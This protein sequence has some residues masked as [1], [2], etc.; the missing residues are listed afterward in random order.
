MNNYAIRDV[1]LPSPS[2]REDVEDR[3]E[4]MYLATL[5]TPLKAAPTERN[6]CY[7][8]FYKRAVPAE[9]NAITNA[10]L[11]APEVPSVCSWFNKI[12]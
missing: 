5:S 7:L 6:P 8:L 2:E 1:V 3:W 9:R 12:K 10:F 4:R 11:N